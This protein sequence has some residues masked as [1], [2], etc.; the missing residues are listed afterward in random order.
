MRAAVLSLALLAASAIASAQSASVDRGTARLRSADTDGNGR[1]SRAEAQARLP[2][3][4]PDFDAIDAD[5]DGSLSPAE[6]RARSSARSR[7]GGGADGFAAH[8]ERAD[9]DG[10][11]MLSRAEIGRSLPR[12]RA[13]F[14]AIDADRN[15]ELTRAELR[16]Y[17]DRHRAARARR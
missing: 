14:D 11:G 9:T 6:L 17:F 3:L 16:A 4:V 12:L 10:N 13:K 7:R 1:I 15:A 8:F 5:R 2:K